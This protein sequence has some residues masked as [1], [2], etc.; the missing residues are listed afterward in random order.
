MRYYVF[1]EPLRSYLFKQAAYQE[2]RAPVVCTA[3]TDE[4][5]VVG[6]SIIVVKTPVGDPALRG[7][8]G[9]CRLFQMSENDAK[10]LQGD[11][12]FATIPAQTRGHTAASI[13]RRFLRE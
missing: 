4:G 6:R 7:L 9:L 11:P 8:L 1:A 3:I 13:F 2:R 10:P 12:F 5:E